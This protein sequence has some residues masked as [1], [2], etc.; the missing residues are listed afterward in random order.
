VKVFNTEDAEEHRVQTPALVAPAHL[1]Y[2]S[3]LAV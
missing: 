1:W 2:L 3:G